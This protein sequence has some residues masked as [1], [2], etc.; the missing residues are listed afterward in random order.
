M[1]LAVTGD[2]GILFVTFPPDFPEFAGPWEQPLNPQH[3]SLNMSKQNRVLLQENMVF[4]DNSWW[5]RK[6]QDNL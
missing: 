2:S 4:M 6:K 3:H 1:G 5:K